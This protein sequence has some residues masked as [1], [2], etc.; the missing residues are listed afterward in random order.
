MFYLPIFA[1][2]VM[3][4]LVF[5]WALRRPVRSKLA[6]DALPP[7]EDP[8]MR[9]IAY[10]PQIQQTLSR[11]D[12]EYLTSKGSAKLA[13]RVKK[14]RRKAALSYVTALQN[15]FDR[16]LRLARVIAVLS[17]EVGA[18]QEFERLRLS[19]QFA[20]RYHLLR[21]LLHLELAPM[22]QL[23]GLS[24]MVSTFAVR[25]QEAMNELGERAALATQMAS[26]LERRGADLS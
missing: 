15:D 22:P 21:I 1:L 11:A 17:P 10:L 6:A 23:S 12:M 24:D 2:V 26:S 5:V 9:H 13:K 16:L 4:L 25:M 8:G 20:M 7:V 18:V 19:A 3:L 14:E